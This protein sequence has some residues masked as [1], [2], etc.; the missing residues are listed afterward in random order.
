MILLPP[1]ESVRYPR[2]LASPVT[3]RKMAK[4]L[5]SKSKKQWMPLT[6]MPARAPSR[7][8]VE[9][10]LLL[11]SI[12]GVT[13]EQLTVAQSNINVLM[14]VA[15]TLTRVMPTTGCHHHRHI[16]RTTLDRLQRS[17]GVRLWHL[18]EG[19]QYLSRLS[20]NTH[21]RRMPAL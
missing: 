16:R 14:V 3:R 21:W 9:L 2:V 12:K 18:L 15:S 1:E 7:L 19:Q 17:L 6:L 4:S 8:F 5:Q 11:L 10:R 13:P 20:A